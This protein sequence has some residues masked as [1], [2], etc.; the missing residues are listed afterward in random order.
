MIT[1]HIENKENRWT[2]NFIAD[3]GNNI[4]L[5]KQAKLSAKKY[6]SG[7]RDIPTLHILDTDD[8]C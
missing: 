7:G 3:Q 8:P 4:D 1:K 6:S 2:N 5:L